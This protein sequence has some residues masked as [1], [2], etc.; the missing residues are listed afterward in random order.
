MAFS[1]AFATAS[2]AAP[3]E[4]IVIGSFRTGMT[5]EELKSAAPQGA[6]TDNENPAMDPKGEHTYRTSGVMT[7]DGRPYDARI[8]SGSFGE[9]E[10]VL[11]RKAQE[12]NA[13]ACMKVYEGLLAELES[14]FGGLEASNLS[15]DKESPLQTFGKPTRTE[16]RRAGKSSSYT[17][18]ET[19]AY[20][21]ATTRQA[22]PPGELRTVGQY[23]VDS[24][25]LGTSMCMTGV[26]ID[27]PGHPP[28]FEEVDAARLKVVRSPSLGT[29]HN[30]LEG[31]AIPATG[32]MVESRCR[33]VRNTGEIGTC[34]YEARPSTELSSALFWRQQE[35]AFDVSGFSGASRV[36]LFANF[37]FRIDPKER[38][39]LGTPTSP[40]S[41]DEIEW[42]KPP[43][44][45]VTRSLI[46]SRINPA[47]RETT[48][49]NAVATTDCMIQPDASL[50]CLAIRVDLGEGVVVE[51]FNYQRFESEAK[52]NLAARRAA[53]TTRSGQ[54]TRGRW[55]HFDLPLRLEHDSMEL[56]RERVEKIRQEREKRRAVPAQP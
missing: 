56:M 43:E 22:L 36:P 17:W 6:W 50:A 2:T 25:L 12:R 21:E 15:Y 49:D 44:L 29:L 27:I 55:V 10:I 18:H 30:S 41:P 23:F 8:H 3:A 1:L 54:P 9:Y 5:L 53:A 48:S 47:P 33:L 14:R 16:K 24:P 19:V 38:L 35:M 20:V 7:L 45:V 39:G 37:V 46:T 31:L 32:I 28:E 26:T 40:L 11:F 52:R 34:E 51:P 42:S 4:P 13:A